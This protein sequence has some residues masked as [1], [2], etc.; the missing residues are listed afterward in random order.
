MRNRTRQTWLHC[1]L[2]A[3]LLT[4]ACGQ[5]AAPAT[6]DG[7]DVQ[8]QIDIQLK[9]DSGG[10]DGALG[11]APH[12]QLTSID[13]A[14]DAAAPDG[15]S[16]AATQKCEFPANPQAGEAGAVCATSSDCNSGFCVDAPTGKVC[17]YTCFD[18]CPTGFACN[19]YAGNGA[20]LVCQAVGLDLCRPC[21]ADAA[22]AKDGSGALCVH[23]GDTGSFC[24]SACVDDSDCPAGF[25]CALSK[26][27]KG[28]AKQCILTQ[29]EC[30]C[31]SAAIAAGAA[32][33]CQLTN[34]L[35]ACAGQRVCGPAGLSLCPAATPTQEVCGD[36]VDNDCNGKTDEIGAQGCTLLFTDGDKDGDGKAGSAGECLCAP[37][38]SYTATTATDCDD[39]NPAVSGKALEV[40]DGMDNNCNGQTDEGCDSDGDGYCN[41]EMQLV[42][43]PAVCPKGGGDCDDSDASVHPGQLE[44]C[45]NFKDDDCD[46]LTDSGPNVSACVPFFQDGDGD[47]YGVGVPVCQCG[48]K[49]GY[50]AVKGGDC[51]DA[52]AAVHPGATEI[53]NGVDDNCDGKTDDPGASG[54]T[55]YFADGDGDGYGVGASVCLCA[56]DKSHTATKGGDCNDAA[57]AISPGATET[58]NGVDDNCDGVTDEPGAVGC[59]T[60]FQDKD[61][62]GFGDPETGACLC[63]ATPVGWT[64]IGTDC[65]DASAAAHPGAAEICDG[66][67]NNCDGVTDG[68]N[69]ADCKNFYV[70]VDGDGYGVAA[71]FSCQ[72]A[73]DATFTASQ[74][75]DCNDNNADIHPGAV[76][77]CDGVDN[78]C[79][80]GIDEAG[81]TGCT[82]YARDHDG[83][84]FGAIGDTK[85]LCAKTGEYTALLATDCND[86]DKAIHPKALE[87]C[88]GVDNDCDGVTDPAGSDGCNNWF[89]DQDQDGYGTYNAPSK[90][91]C[92]G[93]PGYATIGGDCND[94][95]AA[96]NPDATEICNGVDDNC[97]GIIDPANTSGCTVYY[98]DM[99]GDGYGVSNQLECV[100]ASDGIFTATVGG[101]CNDSNKKINP[102]ETEICNNIDDNCNGQTDEG[103]TKAWY[104]D[105]DKD[106]FGAGAAIFACA[107]SGAYTAT[108]A[109]D[110]D[111]NNPAVYPGAPELCDG[112]D[113]NC[114]GQTDEGGSSAKY[115]LDS[116]GDGYGTGGGLILCGTS[117]GYTA[118]VG[119]DCDDTNKAIHPGAAEICNGVDDNCNGLTDEGLATGNYYKDLDGDGYGAGAVVVACSGVG[120]VTLNGDCNDANAAIHP[121]AAEVCDGV[122]NDCNGQTDDGL[123]TST[124]FPDADKDGYGT[125]AGVSACG[126][127]GN[128]TAIVGGDCDDTKASVHPGATEV[129]GNGIDDNCNGQVD[130]GCV[131]PT[132][133]PTLLNGLNS[134]SDTT[135]L[136][137]DSNGNAWQINHI[138]TTPEGSNSLFWGRSSGCGYAIS[139]GTA[140]ATWNIVVPAGATQVTAVV[141]IDNIHNGSTVDTQISA[142]LTLDGVAKSIGPFSSYSAQ[143]KTY[144]WT[145]TSAQWGKTVQMT[146]AVTAPQINSASICTGGVVIDNIRSACN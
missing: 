114:N 16:D 91:L 105:N 102:G 48:V 31:S 8:F 116:D 55:A 67:D 3:G 46:G 126:P 82:V 17:S 11:D 141:G 64:T 90:C 58:C 73:A 39:K 124:Y 60:Y 89:V 24:G 26:G 136:P 78:N 38:D 99:D 104:L 20:S 86:N 80:N 123:A 23:Y 146:A 69:T 36:G 21:D 65:N 118:T 7:P 28:S 139:T 53:C 107:A 41:A 50:T 113:N 93:G 68:A 22:C 140:L 85:C 70:D 97:D 76:E 1:W 61:G 62:D 29:G 108:Q 133:T 132:C 79:V 45:G 15:G 13:A 120:Y 128:N 119:G 115:F 109:G 6:G 10:K 131:A 135:S 101:D 103:L 144:T 75:G 9:L 54:C 88:D 110:C 2:L 30:P 142:V 12:D 98:S 92:T 66:I 94:N 96:I 122:D 19:P 129:C 37:V 33:T 57:A 56:P 143:Y 83:D 100:C 5:T 34:S 59:T 137:S 138:Y 125:G 71:K 47:G 130:E 43:T 14:T 111:D 52:N 27:E 127:L 42:G 121:G 81:A 40:C 106:G 32:T 145:V 35:G 72:C 112:I 51:N 77:V 49:A 95:N 74:D 44:I 84:G 117:G 134:T 4:T 87:V 63:G 18:C 25:G